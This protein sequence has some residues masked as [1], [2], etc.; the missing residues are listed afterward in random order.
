MEMSGHIYRC[1]GGETFDSIALNVYG[2]EK[3]AAELMCA[4][5]ERVDSTVF[6]GGEELRLPVVYMPRAAETGGHAPAWAP[7]KE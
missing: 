3:Y 2:D 6:L 5:P 4:N 1:A 7:W